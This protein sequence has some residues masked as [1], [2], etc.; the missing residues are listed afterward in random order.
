MSPALARGEIRLQ[1]GELLVGCGEETILRV[2]R[3]KVEGRKDV[4]AL[5]FANG[6]HLPSGEHFD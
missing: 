6:A 3:V 1:S 4:S 5:D 2:S